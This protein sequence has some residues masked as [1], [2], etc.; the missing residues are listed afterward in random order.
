MELSREP[1]VLLVAD[2]FVR[3]VV[4]VDEERFP[5][6]SQCVVVYSITVVLRGDE[7]LFRAYHAY[8]LVMAAVT[9]F[10]FVDFGTSCL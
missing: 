10:Q 2:T 6:G 3:T 7:T 4:H 8:R 5:V 9:V 1:G